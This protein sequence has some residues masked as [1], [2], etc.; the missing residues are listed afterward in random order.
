M[1]MRPTWNTARGLH[2]VLF[3]ENNVSDLIQYLTDID[4]TPWQHLVGFV[5]AICDRESRSNNHADLHLRSA[6]GDA[7]IVEVKVGHI[8]DEGQQARYEELGEDTALYLAALPLDGDRIDNNSSVDRWKFLSLVQLFEPWTIVE[9]PAARVFAA[10]IV[11]ILRQWDTD[12][13]AMFKAQTDQESKPLSTLSEKTLA[14]IVTRRIATQLESRGPR[15]YAGVLRGGGIPVVQAR[16]PVTGQQ[17]HRCF[18]A[19]LRWSTPATGELRFGIDFSSSTEHPEDRELRRA[20][21]ALAEAMESFLDFSPLADHLQ[22]IQPN[23]GGLLIDRKHRTWPKAKG[24]WEQV[25]EHGLHLPEG[26]KRRNQIT[27][28]FYGDG[29][30]RFQASVHIDLSIARAPDI[31]DLLAATL[32]YLSAHQP[33]QSSSEST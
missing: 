1:T 26:K 22:K 27:P 32:D 6:T 13:S 15:G 3:G 30:L 28:A 18:I 8:F 9:D 14:R 21:F 16:T 33:D 17:T 24:D 4:P 23:V 19:E 29:A 25:I 7:A 12:M 31:T 2:R 11:S 10:E 20:A 5:P